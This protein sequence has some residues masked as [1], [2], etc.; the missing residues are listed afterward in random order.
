MGEMMGAD[1]GLGPEQIAQ[2]DVAVSEPE[3]GVETDVADVRADGEREGKPVFNVDHGEFYQNMEYGR[4]RLRFKSGSNIQ[5][6]MQQ[7]RYNKPFFIQYK[8]ENGKEYIR[9]VKGGRG[10]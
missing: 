5:Q 2:Q 3:D 4:K 10:R 9:R 7:T 6:Y 8:D 1:D